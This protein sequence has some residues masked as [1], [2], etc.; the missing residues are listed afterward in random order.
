VLGSQLASPP[1]YPAGRS[2]GS[3]FPVRA[4]SA[5]NN[6]DVLTN[7]WIDDR[8]EYLEP[9]DGRLHEADA[10]PSPRGRRQ[11]TECSCSGVI[12]L[13]QNREP[14]PG[15]YLKIIRRRSSMVHLRPMSAHR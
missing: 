6:R 8:E 15:D 2:S 13:Q 7:G 3:W 1:T 5:V 14:E 12:G 11:M 4:L 9:L 10:V